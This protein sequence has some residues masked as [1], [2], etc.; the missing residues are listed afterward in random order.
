MAVAAPAIRGNAERAAKARGI[1][2]TVLAFAVGLWAGTAGL[3]DIVVEYWEDIAYLTPQHIMLTLIS[4][5]LA[6]LVGIPLGGVAQPPAHAHG[7][8]IGHAGAQHRHHG[9]DARRA[10]AEHGVFSASA[11][12]RRCSGCGWPPCCR[13]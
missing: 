4:G 5:G 11:P 6:I 7:G 12:C 1:A 8:R 2:L 10:G 9:P 3:I 13:S